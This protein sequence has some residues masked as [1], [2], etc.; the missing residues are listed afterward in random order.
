M[1]K[2]TCSQTSSSAQD[3]E[4]ARL[5][6]NEHFKEGNELSAY[7][8]PQGRYAFW[9]VFGYIKPTLKG[10]A[11]LG[12]LVLVNLSR[13]F[14]YS[15]VPYDGQESGSFQCKRRAGESVCALQ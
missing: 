5:K 13:C 9:L 2:Q 11:S 12:V 1:E 8:D 7:Q 14:F 4:E 15:N 10:I 6:G 3:P